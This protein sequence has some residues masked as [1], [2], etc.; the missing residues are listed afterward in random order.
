MLKITLSDEHL[1]YKKCDL[2]NS[3]QYLAWVPVGIAL[4]KLVELLFPNQLD[5]SGRQ[6]R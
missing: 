3:M 6:N 5:S 4:Q 1:E 2:E